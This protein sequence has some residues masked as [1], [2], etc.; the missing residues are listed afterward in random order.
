[1]PRRI[2]KDIL[3]GLPGILLARDACT[4]KRVLW[5]LVLSVNITRWSTSTQQAYCS[6]SKYCTCVDWH[7]N[8]FYW[9]DPIFEGKNVILMVV[10]RFSKYAHFVA[11]SYL[12]TALLVERIFFEHIV[13]LHGLLESFLCDRDVTSTSTFWKVFFRLSGTRLFF[14]SVPPTIWRA[15]RG[16]KSRGRN[17][18]EMFFRRSAEEVAFMAFMCRVLLQH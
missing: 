3:S 7:C 5:Q 12:Y 9:R 1:M 13:K 14:I 11:L 4:N 16:R 17:V 15:Y 18:L 6:H 8:G 10:D 2:P